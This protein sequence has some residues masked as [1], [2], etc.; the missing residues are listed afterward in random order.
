MNFFQKDALLFTSNP[1]LDDLDLDKFFSGI[2]KKEVK[3][4][5]K[6]I[7]SDSQLR[8]VKSVKSNAKIAGVEKYVDVA[9]MD[10]EWL[11]AKF[12]GGAIS[13]IITQPPELSKNKSEPEIRKILNEF[14]HQAEFILA[15]DGKVIA[16]N[17][18]V[19]L[20]KEI[21]QNHNFKVLEERKVW[22]GKQDYGVVVLEK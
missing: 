11:D 10:I 21:A 13:H 8:H 3:P 7:A 4:K 1:K 20:L 16:F 18:S 5:V 14:F 12:D 6:L 9:R 19:A 17:R 2:D 22:S 15:K